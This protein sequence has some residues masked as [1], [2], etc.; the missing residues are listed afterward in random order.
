MKAIKLGNCFGKTL[1]WP[2][3]T[4]TILTILTIL[5][6]T[7]VSFLA[8][9]KMERR[10]RPVVSAFFLF[11]L[12]WLARVVIGLVMSDRPNTTGV[13][14]HFCWA[15]AFVIDYAPESS[16]LKGWLTVSPQLCDISV[17]WVLVVISYEGL[18]CYQSISPVTF[19]TSPSV[20]PQRRLR[21][22]WVLCLSATFEILTA[23]SSK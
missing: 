11:P 14:P 10:Q 2:S 19:K 13:M 23:P 21:V 1:G 6:T 5:I 3:I 18:P 20:Y 22:L 12:L 17:L 4:S 16:C 15:V 9:R 7:M 8:S